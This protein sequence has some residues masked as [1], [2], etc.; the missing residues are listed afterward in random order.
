MR[1]SLRHRRLKGKERATT[2]S[3]H[4]HDLSDNE[5]VA[6]DDGQSQ[7]KSLIGARLPTTPARKPKTKFQLTATL[8][9]TSQPQPSRERTRAASRATTSPPNG[10]SSRTC[11]QASPYRPRASLWFS[12][13]RSPQPAPVP[14]ASGYSP[15]AFI[16]HTK[17]YETNRKRIYGQTVTTISTKPKAESRGESQ[18]EP[19]GESPSSPCTYT[20]SQTFSTL[21][22]I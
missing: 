6:K 11:A 15:V 17:E 10:C 14:Q 2:D 16:L 22:P 4:E 8:S 3:I 12:S 20:Y 5:V 1:R 9:P 19:E 18:C 7:T 21:G 13:P